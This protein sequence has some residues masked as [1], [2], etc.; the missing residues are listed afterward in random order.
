MKI[1]M[2]THGSS[3]VDRSLQTRRSV[4]SLGK[5]QAINSRQTFESISSLDTSQHWSL[6]DSLQMDSDTC[7]VGKL[8]A[9]PSH[10]H[11]K[12]KTKMH[13]LLG[14][15][16][17]RPNAQSHVKS[18]TGPVPKEM[19]MDKGMTS[20]HI[21]YKTATKARARQY[22]LNVHRFNH[23]S[24]TS[25]HLCYRAGQE[26]SVPRASSIISMATRTCTRW[27]NEKDGCTKKSKQKIRIAYIKLYV[28]AVH[29]RRRAEGY[30]FGYP[31]GVSK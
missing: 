23:P 4:Q 22:I 6:G 12:H 13:M 9:L 5:S 29:G 17:N 2:P 30:Q 21:A 15:N 18:Q 24:L 3:R 28:V 16:R 26:I 11:G 31:F 14:V 27:Y 8:H 25:D 19:T 10:E 20:K 1:G 7:S